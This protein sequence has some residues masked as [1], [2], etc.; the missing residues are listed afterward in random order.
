MNAM[1][2]RFHGQELRVGWSVIIVAQLVW[3]LSMIVGLLEMQANALLA[4][5]ELTI[6]GVMLTALWIN[7]SP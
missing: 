2:R 3:A 5:I 7:Q 6:I 4:G 1:A